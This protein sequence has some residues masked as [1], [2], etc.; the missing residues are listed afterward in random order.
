MRNVARRRKK[1]EARRFDATGLVAHSKA[2]FAYYTDIFD[3][4]MRGEKVEHSTFPI[5]VFDRF[6]EAADRE[7]QEERDRRR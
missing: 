1:L 2:W 6:V 5:E 4:G 3:R 7:D